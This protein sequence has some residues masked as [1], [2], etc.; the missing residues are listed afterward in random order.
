MNM[1]CRQLTR[2]QGPECLILHCSSQGTHQC[3][4]KVTYLLTAFSCSLQ[5]YTLFHEPLVLVAEGARC[6][7]IPRINDGEVILCNFHLL[8]VQIVLCLQLH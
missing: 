4:N 3:L 5:G 8:A 2:K 6:L 1:A 7:L